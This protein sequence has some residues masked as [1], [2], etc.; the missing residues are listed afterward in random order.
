MKLL[1]EIWAVI[2]ARAGSKGLKDKNIK[3]FQNKPLIA[4]SIISAKKN[5]VISKV[6]FSS[7]SKRYISLAK[8]FN[9]EIYHLRSKISSRDNST[10]FD[11]FKEITN[12]FLKKKNKF[13]EIF[14][15][16]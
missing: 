11:V 13:T 3:F 1:N 10:D 14:Y 7:D 9:C 16:F 8:K 6:I 2:P 12:Y 15:S 4:H 5:N